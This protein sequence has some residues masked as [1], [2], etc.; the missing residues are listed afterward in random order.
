MFDCSAAI[1][2][3]TLLCGL[4]QNMAAKRILIIRTAGLGDTVLMWPAV[5]AV[6]VRYPDASIDVMG[7][8]KRVE[9]LTVPGGIDRALDVE[10][11][12][13]HH[14]FEISTALPDAVCERFGGYDTIAVFAGE[15]DYALAENLSACGASE[16]HA[17]LPL[18]RA[19]EGLRVA[20]Y[21]QK[22][23]V[24]QGLGEHVS[25]PPLPVTEAE[26]EAALKRL[27]ALGLRGEKLACVAPGSGSSAKNFEPTR[28]ARLCG[29]LGRLGVEP[30]LIEGP[31]DREAIAAVQAH[32]DGAGLRVLSDDPPRVLKG[33]FDQ[34]CLVV[35][36][37]SGP[38][39]LAAMLGVATVA[40][41]GPS[42]PELWAPIDP[43]CAVVASRVECAPCTEDEM[44]ACGDR[45]CLDSLRVEDV[46][47]ACRSLLRNG[48]RGD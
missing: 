4:F 13:L 36:N 42:D 41:F 27:G 18:P 1:D 30:V 9:L 7:H 38:V 40:I 21:L 44:H 31:A 6:R 19:G 26:R 47:D 5:H 23:L 39:Q 48:S 3:D 37:D 43:R 25:A 33:I 12:G 34:A 10:G 2:K 15:G 20:D 29:E 17:F 24:D 28:F 16:V 14:L 32:P 11:S 46:L 8:K 22:V 35:G 45:A